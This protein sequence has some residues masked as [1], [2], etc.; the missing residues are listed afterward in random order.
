MFD[1]ITKSTITDNITLLES[2]HLVK[3]VL[4]S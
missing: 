2:S 4:L 3:S 1:K